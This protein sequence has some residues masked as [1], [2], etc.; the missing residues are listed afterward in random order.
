MSAAS[1]WHSRVPP[2][3]AQ[4]LSCAV[5]AERLGVARCSVER[6]RR[7]MQAPAPAFE[8]LPPQTW[9]ALYASG[10]SLARIAVRTE[11]S[12]RRVRRELVAQGVTLRAPG[13]RQGPRPTWTTSALM[14][15]YGCAATCPRRIF[16]LRDRTTAVGSC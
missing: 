4:G 6:V 1:N 7:G 8:D 10:T 5:I 15:R 9:P 14:A 2:L 11:L 13:N 16:C 12:L 3:L